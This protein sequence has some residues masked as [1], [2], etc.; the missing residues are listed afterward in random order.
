MLPGAA[1]VHTVA[2]VKHCH[3]LPLVN[4]MVGQYWS[5]FII[6]GISKH[7]EVTGTHEGSTKLSTR[8]EKIQYKLL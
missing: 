4:R 2:Y 6:C 8:L 7:V 5:D 1:H 3:F